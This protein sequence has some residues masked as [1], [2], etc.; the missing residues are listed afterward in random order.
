MCGGIYAV[1]NI[2]ILCFHKYMFICKQYFHK[3]GSDWKC[4]VLK[5]SPSEKTEFIFSLVIQNSSKVRSFKYC[6]LHGLGT[7]LTGV[8]GNEEATNTHAEK[9]GLSGSCHLRKMYHNSL[10]TAS[11]LYTQEKRGGSLGNLS[12]RSL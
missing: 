2:K 1:L 6:D 7:G 4:Y 10:E 9:L 12:R 8:T 5:I 11:L 3:G